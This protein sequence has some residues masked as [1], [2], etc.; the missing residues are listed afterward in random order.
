MIFFP[1][2]VAVRK[3]L[4]RHRDRRLW[5]GAEVVGQEDAQELDPEC[6]QLTLHLQDPGCAGK[7]PLLREII[8][9][10]RH[11]PNLLKLQRVLN[12]DMGFEL[13]YSA[14][15]RFTLQSVAA[16][17]QLDSFYILTDVN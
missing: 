11:C 7:G 9:A 1:E 10:Q 5:V 16:P 3:I 6:G 15:V 4:P 12:W 13:V 17:R 14:W 2:L 8:D